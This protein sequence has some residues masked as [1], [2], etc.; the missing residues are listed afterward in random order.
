M[1]DFGKGLMPTLENKYNEAQ[2]NRVKM[3]EFM[4]TM[5]KDSV[6]NLYSL[7]YPR[8]SLYD[9]CLNFYAD[10]FEV[11]KKRVDVLLDYKEGEYEE[12]M[13]KGLDYMI[14]NLKD[15][16]YSNIEIDSVFSQ[17]S[18]LVFDKIYNSSCNKE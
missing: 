16:G 15:R 7:G 12:K 17:S 8:D 3:S 18:E 10:G 2:G 11:C 9:F 1:N 5:T 4:D 13:N 14:S 6:R